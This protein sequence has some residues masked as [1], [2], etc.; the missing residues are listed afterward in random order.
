MVG[1]NFSVTFINLDLLQC[2]TINKI[3]PLK[4]A[5]RKGGLILVKFDARFSFSHSQQKITI[6]NG[7]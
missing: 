2:Y 5:G 7:V 4:T 6:S 1:Y 3:V